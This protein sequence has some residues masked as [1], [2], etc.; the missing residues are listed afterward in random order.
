MKKRIVYAI[1]V[2]FLVGLLASCSSTKMSDSYNH[3]T[4]SWLLDSKYVDTV[5]QQTVLTILDF[6]ADKTVDIYEYVPA[7]EQPATVFRTDSAVPDK[8]AFTL[9][10]TSPVNVNGN[11][12][13]YQYQ[14]NT[15]EATFSVELN[16]L[17]VH[18]YVK[19]EENK[20]IHEIYK[21]AEKE[22][23]P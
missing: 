8:S 3:L 15:I 22:K 14:G 17:T 6:K 12:I 7:E 20:T 18:M 5:P 13:S 10:E 4:G 19:N 2:I 1:T 16:S 9:K 23:R 21:S 11:T